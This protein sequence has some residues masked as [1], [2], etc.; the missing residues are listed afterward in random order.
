MLFPNV[1]VYKF[2]RVMSNHNPLV[3]SSQK[4]QQKR[5]R[6]FRF[7]LSWLSGQLI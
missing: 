4:G 5:V 1:H 7:E 6:T 3:V 2:P